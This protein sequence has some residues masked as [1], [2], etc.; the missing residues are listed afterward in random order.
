MTHIYDSQ[1]RSSLKLLK[2]SIKRN[3]RNGN[4]HSLEVTP[5]QFNGPR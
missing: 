2:Q 5:P 4:L 3:G 1:S